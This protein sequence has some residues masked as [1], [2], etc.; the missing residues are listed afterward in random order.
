MRKLL[1]I[2]IIYSLSIL[3]VAHAHDILRDASFLTRGTI[4]NERIESSSIT[5][6]GSLTTTPSDGDCI[7]YQSGGTLKSATCG[8]EGGGSSSLAI[9]T[10][11]VQAAN[12]VSRTT[13]GINLSSGTHNIQVTGGSTAFITLRGSSVTLQGN[14]VNISTVAGG[15][16]IITDR[17]NIFTSTLPSNVILNTDLKQNATFYVSSGTVDGNLIVIGSAS[18]SGISI[19]QNVGSNRDARI[20][21]NDNN[22]TGIYQRNGVAGNISFRTNGRDMLFISDGDITTPVPGQY[23]ANVTSG[24]LRVAYSFGDTDSGLYGYGGARYPAV[25]VDGVSVMEWATP[26]VSRTSFTVMEVVTS[27]VGFIAPSS[28]FA[29]SSVQDMRASSLTVTGGTFTVNNTVMVF[30]SSAPPAGTDQIFHLKDGHSPDTL[31][32]AGLARS[33]HVFT[34]HIDAPTGEYS[35]RKPRSSM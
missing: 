6:L 29:F 35:Q 28:T 8:G 16:Q 14:L 3:G 9:A 21:F 2:Y 17:F 27:S 20:F 1:F 31:P 10:G 24:P 22:Q 4:P 30:P 34:S 5:K 25:S 11:S 32:A 23:I 26:I 18:V 12:I 13:A 33:G 15:L 7:Q 19:S